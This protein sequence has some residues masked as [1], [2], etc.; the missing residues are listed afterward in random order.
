MRIGH[1]YDIHRLI[2]DRPLRLGGVTVPHDR[3]LLGH[4]DGDVVLHAI[5]DAL[6]GAMGAEDMGHLFPDTEPQFKDIDSAELVREVL[7]RVHETGYLVGNLDVTIY[8]ERPK[9]APH[10]VAMRERIAALLAVGVD[11]ASIKAKTT[12][13]LGAVGRGEAIA[14]T[15]VVLLDRES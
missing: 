9:L 13:G 5:C 12:E 11:Q 2:P 6:L 4:S 14:A 7:R 3:G 8:A 10:K 1:G 15:A